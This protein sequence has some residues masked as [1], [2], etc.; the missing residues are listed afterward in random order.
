M[1]RSWGEYLLHQ[2]GIWD[3]LEGALFSDDGCGSKSDNGLFRRLI[4]M[5]AVSER[6][7]LFIDDRAK[8]VSSARELGLSVAHFASVRGDATPQGVGLVSSLDDLKRLVLDE[9]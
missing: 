1:P 7:I 4:D 2:S 6:E 8:H 3:L 5:A 9:R